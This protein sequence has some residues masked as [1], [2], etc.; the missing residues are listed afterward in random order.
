MKR[1]HNP[2]KIVC[3]LGGGLGNQMFCY[4]SGLAAAKQLGLKMEIDVSSY[5]HDGFGR[6]YELKSFNI[7]APVAELKRVTFLDK[8]FRKL[9]LIPYYKITAQN[10]ITSLE[11]ISSRKAVTRDYFLNYEW[12]SQN[13]K[14]FDSYRSEV[15]E[16]FAYIGELSDTFWKLNKDNQEYHTIAVHLRYGDYVRLGCVMDPDFYAEAMNRAKEAIGETEKIR[17]VVFSE[18]IESAKEILKPLVDDT[19][20]L[21]ISPE[22]GLTDLEEFWLMKNCSHYIISNSTFSWWAAYLGESEDSKVFAPVLRNW[23][24]NCWEEDYFPDN[25]HKIEASVMKRKNN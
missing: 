14:L 13:Y 18:D 1:E 9:S 10:S 17:F 11:E 3:E 23:I 21:Y 12:H 6:Q 24:P 16:Q 2:R 25:W 22:Y 4:A 5:A 15:K 8:V 19:Q 20:V 7:Q